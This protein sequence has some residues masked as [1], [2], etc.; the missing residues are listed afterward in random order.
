MKLA[1]CFLTR[2][3]LLQAALWQEFFAAGPAADFAIYCHPK[4]PDAVTSPVLAGRV[5]ERRVLTSPAHISLVE[6]TLALFA[7]AFRADDANEYFILL[8]ESTIPI[9]SFGEIYAELGAA[10]SCS[11]IAWQACLPGSEHYGRLSNIAD[12]ARFA[13]PFYSHDQWIVLHRRHVGA[14]LEKSYLADFA[15]VF[16]PDEHYF[17]NVLVHALRVP[18]DQLVNR[19]TSFVSWLDPEVRSTTDPATGRL[20]SRTIHPKTF[21]SL[22]AWDLFGAQNHWFLRKVTAS[23]DCSL[24]LARVRSPAAWRNPRPIS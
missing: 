1:F 7:A 2:A 13:N 11:L 23:C 10:E 18:L 8:S 4:E 19:R 3:D 5:I 12:G 16:A 6:A 21:T 22:S 20:L 15:R 14:L 9:M 17:M 24:A